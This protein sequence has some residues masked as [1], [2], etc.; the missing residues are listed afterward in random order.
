MQVVVDVVGVAQQDLNV[1][2]QTILLHQACMP[3]HNHAFT[4]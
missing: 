4:L 3:F 2:W 1:T